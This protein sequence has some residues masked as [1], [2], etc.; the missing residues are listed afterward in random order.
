MLAWYRMVCLTPSFPHRLRLI[1]DKGALHLHPLSRI[2]QMRTALNYLDDAE[3]R[4]RSRRGRGFDDEE[5]EK[6]EKKPKPAAPT[7]PIKALRK[8]SLSPFFQVDESELG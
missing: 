3:E 1:D 8:V 2:L 7:V 6:E 5:E 4:S